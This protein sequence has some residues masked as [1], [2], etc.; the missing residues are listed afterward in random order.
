MSVPTGHSAFNSNIKLISDHMTLI[1]TFSFQGGAEFLLH[2]A[3][4]GFQLLVN[5]IPDFSD[6]FQLSAFN[7]SYNL[8]GECTNQPICFQLIIKPES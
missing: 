6:G 1:S 5:L 3:Y 8:K 2:E 4:F 7:S